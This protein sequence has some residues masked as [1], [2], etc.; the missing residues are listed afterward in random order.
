MHLEG[1]DTCDWLPWEGGGGTHRSAFPGVILWYFSEFKM[2]RSLNDTSQMFPLR[3]LE[4]K[5]GWVLAFSHF[6]WGQLRTRHSEM[7]PHVADRTEL[8]YHLI[9]LNINSTSDHLSEDCT[10]CAAG[11][12]ECAKAEPPTVSPSCGLQPGEAILE[13]A[14]WEPSWR[15]CWRVHRT[16]KNDTLQKCSGHVQQVRCSRGDAAELRCH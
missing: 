13:W 15:S 11:Q 10:D 2:K 6:L 4:H 7:T 9:V 16:Q 5:L 3:R 14:V 12:A 8:H 1:C